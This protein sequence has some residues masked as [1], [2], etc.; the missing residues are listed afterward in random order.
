MSLVPDDSELVTYVKN[1]NAIEGIFA[2]PSDEWH[3]GYHVAAA[4]FVRSSKV[5]LPIDGIHAAIMVRLLE[6]G[7]FPG[8][9]R[10]QS[11]YYGSR[12]MPRPRAVPQLMHF[13][14]DACINV[15]SEYESGQLLGNKLVVALDW[16]H[17]HAL[18]IHPFAD[19]NG[20]TFR[21]YLNHVRQRCGLPWR[22]YHPQ[23]DEW[24]QLLSGLRTYEKEVFRPEYA[25][26]YDPDT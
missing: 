6:S 2:G 14:Y 8:E 4:R 17:H 19:G 12:P 13:W 24:S 21:L 10:T 3:W 22:L 15:F 20:R 23:S 16:L 7:D 9:Y 1:S 25:H 5:L 18:C 11:A 26:A